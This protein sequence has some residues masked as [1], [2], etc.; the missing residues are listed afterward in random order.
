M[1]L[2]TNS[3]ISTII[4]EALMFYDIYSF[5]KHASQRVPSFYTVMSCQ[6]KAGIIDCEMNQ[7]SIKA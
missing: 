7:S 2:Q 3:P 5:L 6:I 4:Y 1:S